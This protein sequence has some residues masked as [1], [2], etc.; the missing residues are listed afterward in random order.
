MSYAYAGNIVPVMRIDLNGVRGDRVV[1][2]MECREGIF[3]STV[4]LNVDQIVWAL[5][6]E[7]DRYPAVIESIDEDDG[8]IVLRIDF[9]NTSLF[10]ETSSIDSQQVGIS[11]FGMELVG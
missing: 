2:D 11:V 9:S 7:G 10:E 4:P 6:E 8:T 3:D 5:E 1:T